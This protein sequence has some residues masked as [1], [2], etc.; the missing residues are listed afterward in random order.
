MPPEASP[1][2]GAD[3]AEDVAAILT[4]RHDNG[5]DFWASPEAKVYVGHPFSTIGALGMLHELGLDAT[6]EAVAGGLDL[7]LEASRP[8]GRIRLGPKT[9]MYPCYT[10]EAARTLCRF[11][12]AEHEVLARCF[13]Y[14]LDAAHE[15]GGWRCSFS[16]FG[17]GPETAFANPGATLFV[18]DALRF[19]P[20]LRAGVAV[21]DAAVD[22]L[23]S[24]WETRLPLGPCHYGIGSRFLKLEY[25]MLR[26]NLFAFVHVLSFYPRATAD[27]RF[28]EALAVLEEKVDEEGRVRVESPHRSLKGLRFCAKGEPSAPATAR[29]GEI[30]A[31]LA[32]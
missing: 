5:A 18:L 29:Y 4:H 23:L 22:S 11:G 17:K 27:P 12:L 1:N 14:F 8:D 24:H 16:R 26:Y 6:H 13:A 15:T 25:P 31:N 19:R 30:R 10:A 2:G 3:L 20:E 28:R 32:A 9:P 7:L 21:V